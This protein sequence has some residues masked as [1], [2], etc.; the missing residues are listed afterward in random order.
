[1]EP[2]TVNFALTP[3]EGDGA[4]DGVLVGPEGEPVPNETVLLQSVGTRTHLETRSGSSG[5]FSFG[6]F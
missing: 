3:S 2:F 6:L 5:R 4:I 1:M